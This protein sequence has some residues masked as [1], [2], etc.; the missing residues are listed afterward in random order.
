MTSLESRGVTEVVTPLSLPRLETMDGNAK[1]YV[2]GEI[3]YKLAKQSMYYH[4]SSNA[5]V[6]KRIE[7][8]NRCLERNLILS[9]L[10]FTYRMFLGATY[11]SYLFYI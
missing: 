4:R 1:N 6:T 2:I 8:K 7:M 5:H 11:F 10:V 3:V 9:K